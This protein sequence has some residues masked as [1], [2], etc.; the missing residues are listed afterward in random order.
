MKNY[1]YFFKDSIAPPDSPLFLRNYGFR[2]DGSWRDTPL[3]DGAAGLVVDDRFLP[4]P[5]GLSR[6][7]KAL[8]AWEGLLLLDFERPPAPPLIRL[9]EELAGHPLIVPPSYAFRPHRAVLVGPWAGY[10]SFRIWLDRQQSS[11]GHLVLDGAPIRLL[12]RP[13]QGCPT[14]WKAPLPRDGFFCPGAGCLH[15]RLE[16]GSI[17]FWDTAQ[18]L[19]DRCHAAGVPSLIFPEDW[20]AL[21]PP[22][23]A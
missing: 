8:S 9:T 19:T 15:R 4:N 21:N 2:S 11:W 6:A 13:G 3:P 12:A 23:S 22:P 20:A 5:S 17:L 14:H 10:G 7:L 18:T 16:D 1:L